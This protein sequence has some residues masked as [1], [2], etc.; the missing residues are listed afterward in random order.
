M[1]SNAKEAWKDRLVD[2]HFWESTCPFLSP[3]EALS[4][5][6]GQAAPGKRGTCLRILGN[7]LLVWTFPEEGD[8]SGLGLWI[9]PVTCIEELILPL[10]L[11][12]CFC[13]FSEAELFLYCSHTWGTF[14][15]DTVSC[16]L[17][18]IYLCRAVAMLTLFLACGP[19][20]SA[21]SQW[22]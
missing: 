7:N 21:G 20:L 15:P 13:G 8:R 11:L 9:F 17:R 5:Y 12:W 10:S 19:V 4:Q 14:C 2:R 16:F 6:G 1:F 18:L 22:S 3:L